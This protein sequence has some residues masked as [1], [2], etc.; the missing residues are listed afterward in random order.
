MG[1]FDYLMLLLVHHFLARFVLLLLP[2]I[3][4]ITCLFRYVF[5]LQYFFDA[6]G[7]LSVLC[8]LYFLWA[9]SW[10][11]ADSLD[12]HCSSAWL[13]FKKIVLILIYANFYFWD[14]FTCVG[15]M[16]FFFLV[17]V[18]KVLL[19]WLLLIVWLWSTPVHFV[20]LWNLLIF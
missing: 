2:R 3:S 4:R 13:V 7:C 8:V 11:M 12:R 20:L 17:F 1:L 6:D 10:C 9:I 15:I 5:C 19:C 14:A 16:F 18:L